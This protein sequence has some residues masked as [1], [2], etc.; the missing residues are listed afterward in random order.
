MRWK[1]NI[2]NFRITVLAS[3]ERDQFFSKVDFL[4]LVFFCCC[5]C[6]FVW[7]EIIFILQQ[8]PR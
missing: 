8:L 3:E 6:L 4:L 1:G 7:N 5:C 2:D